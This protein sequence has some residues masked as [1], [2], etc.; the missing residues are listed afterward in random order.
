[1]PQMPAQVIQLPGTISTAGN[2]V[3]GLQSLATALQQ[4]L[5]RKLSPGTPEADNAGQPVP[6]AAQPNPFEPAPTAAVAQSKASDDQMMSL[7]QAILAR[8]GR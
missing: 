8:G 1:M 2:A 7:L 3:G 4:M 6:T 5:G